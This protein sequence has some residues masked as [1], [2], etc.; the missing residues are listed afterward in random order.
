MLFHTGILRAAAQFPLTGVIT[1]NHSLLYATHQ[2]T[3]TM[4]IVAASAHQNGR[5]KS[6]IRPSR[7]NTIQKTLRSTN[8][9]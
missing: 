5:M 1:Q 7:A 9:F 6:A 2:L 4:G 8:L 3:I